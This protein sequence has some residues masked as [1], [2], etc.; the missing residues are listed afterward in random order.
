MVLLTER[1]EATSVATRTKHRGVPCPRR[2]SR[3]PP[4]SAG[5]RRSQTYG[6]CSPRVPDPH[7]RRARRGRQEPA[8]A[9]GLR[10]R[11]APFPG[12]RRVRPVGD[13]RRPGRR[14]ARARRPRGRA[15]EGGQAPLDVAIDRLPGQRML[16][17]IDNFEQVLEAGPALATLLDACP[18]VSALVTSRRPLRLRGERQ[19]VVEPL[20]L[21]AVTDGRGAAQG[22]LDEALRSPAVDVVRRAR[23]TGAPRFQCRAG[24]RRGD[25]GPRPSPRRPAARHRAGRG[26]GARPRPRTDAGTARR[27]HRGPRVGRSR[28]SRTAAHAARDARVEPRPAD[29]LPADASRAARRVRRRGHARGDRGRVLGSAGRR[30]ARR[31]LGAPRQRARACRPATRRGA[32][33]VRA[34][35]DG[36]RV[37]TR[38]P[39]AAARSPGRRV[40]VHRLGTSIR[41]RRRPRAAPGCCAALAGSP[42]RGPQP[43]SRRRAAHRLG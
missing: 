42:G 1:F 39:R 27:Q 11:A 33:A 2:R 37:R 16:L 17:L 18:G 24:Q 43:A 29:L 20:A 22:A 15:V 38:A 7:P 5:T 36:A 14:L 10:E 4:P 31:P 23:A 21:P 34:V 9:R 32:A 35:H 26:A 8:G 25:G 12:R 3:S 6:G 41:R 40:P 28:P 13:G 19:L 30:P